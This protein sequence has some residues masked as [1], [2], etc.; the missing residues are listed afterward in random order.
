M[1]FSNAQYKYSTVITHQGIVIAFAARSHDG[2]GDSSGYEIGYTVLSPSSQSALEDQAWTDF[3]LL[4]FP[5]EL[6]LWG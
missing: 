2:E 3:Q 5:K 6:R 4:D 1:K